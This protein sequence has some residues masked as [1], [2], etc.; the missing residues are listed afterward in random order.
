M[1][2]DCST[3]K[4]VETEQDCDA[5]VLSI[6]QPTSSYSRRSTEYCDRVLLKYSGVSGSTQDALDDGRTNRHQKQ[7]NTSNNVN[8]G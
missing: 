4:K 2:S 1:G 6:L 8:L 7:T 5:T 3:C